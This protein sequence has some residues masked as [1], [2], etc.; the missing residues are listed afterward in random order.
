M[1]LLL[2]SSSPQKKPYWKDSWII[3]GFNIRAGEQYSHK[4]ISSETVLN[5]EIGGSYLDLNYSPVIYGQ[6][7]SIKGLERD[8][9]AFFELTATVWPHERG[10][11]PVNV[12]VQC[13]F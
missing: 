1:N 2:I 12:C 8:W 13:L 3:L 7:G 4:M 5:F 6:Q 11:F 9:S 10:V